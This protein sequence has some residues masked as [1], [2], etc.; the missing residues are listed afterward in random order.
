MI[1]N[2]CGTPCSECQ[3]LQDQLDRQHEELR[4]ARAHFRL[5]CEMLEELGRNELVKTQSA[6]EWRKEIEADVA[7]E[8]KKP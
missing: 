3:E 1:C 4:A 2:K 6:R 8:E 7:K 5:A